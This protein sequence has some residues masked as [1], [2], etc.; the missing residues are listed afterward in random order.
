MRLPARQARARRGHRPEQM[1]AIAPADARPE[2]R[3]HRPKWPDQVLACS[4]EVVA[5]RD[6]FRAVHERVVRVLREV[7]VLPSEPQQDVL[8]LPRVPAQP[9]EVRPVQP[10]RV[11][12]R[13]RQQVRLRARALVRPQV[14]RHVRRAA[15]EAAPL[16]LWVRASVRRV[17]VSVSAAAA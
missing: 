3:E 10:P 1:G 14:Q 16:A 11:R 9:L 17:R 5:F 4:R 6:A 13:G 7:R 8:P 12:L 2:Q 15:E